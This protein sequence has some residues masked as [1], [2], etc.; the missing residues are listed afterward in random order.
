MMVHVEL[1]SQSLERFIMDKC[2]KSIHFAL[3][4]S[5]LL[6]AAVED[7]P[8][9]SSRCYRLQELVEV[10]TV[11][12]ER[13]MPVEALTVAANANLLLSGDGLAIVRP[14]GA[15]EGEETTRD[16]SPALPRMIPSSLNESLEFAL[17]KMDRCEYFNKVQTR[18]VLSICPSPGLCDG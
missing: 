17:S 4:V 2:S 6:Q 11:N 16:G 8:A 5:W 18:F 1:E 9:K 3:Q 14:H 12:C 13:P 10:A 7:N 15:A